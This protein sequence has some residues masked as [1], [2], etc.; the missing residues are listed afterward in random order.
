MNRSPSAALLVLLALATP[1]AAVQPPPP[2]SAVQPSRPSSIPSAVRWVRQLENEIEHLQEDLYYDRRSYPQQ[3]SEQTEQA[4]RAV[5]H[6]HQV[7]RRDSDREHLMRDFEE[8]DRQVHQLIDSLNQ[9]GDSWLR[10]QASRIRYSD[11]QLHYVLQAANPERQAVSRELLARHAHVLESEAENLLDLV[12]RRHRDG[13]GVRDA[14]AQFAEEAEHFHQVVEEGADQEHLQEDFRGV[15]EAWHRVVDALNRSSYS[16][17]ERRLAQNVNR[18]HNQIHGMLSGDRTPVAD[19]P[20]EPRQRVER[21]GN[22]P[23]IEFEIP[24]IGRFTIPQ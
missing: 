3:L 10:R 24:G 22:R 1:A 4:S 14:I 7:L 21:R 17:Y 13:D 6:F 20:A 19:A 8:M 5:A 16:F 15:D 18:V 9:S 2:T 11:E 12:S 23:A